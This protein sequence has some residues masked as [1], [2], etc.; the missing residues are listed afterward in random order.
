MSALAVFIILASGVAYMVLVAYL[1]DW[2][3]NHAGKLALLVT[4]FSLLLAAVVARLVVM[5][6]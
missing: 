1:H 3:W 5:S 4:V 6:Q 2:D